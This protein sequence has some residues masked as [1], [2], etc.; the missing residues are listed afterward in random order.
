[1]TL[2]EAQV[3]Q[4]H[5]Q[6]QAMSLDPAGS[7]VRAPVLNTAKGKELFPHWLVE[8]HSTLSGAQPSPELFGVALPRLLE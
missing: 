7:S 4:S 8:M 6:R 5:G 3:L 2:L 1:M